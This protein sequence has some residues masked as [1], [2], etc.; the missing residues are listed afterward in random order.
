[1]H[2]INNKDKYGRVI[3]RPIRP[4]NDYPMISKTRKVSKNID[5]TQDKDKLRK[6]A[7]S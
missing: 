6:H 4:V 5:F 1:M 2:I 7:K 3:D